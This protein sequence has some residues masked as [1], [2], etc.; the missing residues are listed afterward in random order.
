MLKKEQKK[1][2]LHLTYLQ[3]KKVKLTAVPTNIVKELL[4]LQFSQVCNLFIF[5]WFLIYTLHIY[6]KLLY[7]KVFNVLYFSDTDDENK[8]KSLEENHSYSLPESSNSK[9]NKPLKISSQ[10]LLGS[11]RLEYILIFMF[12]FLL[13]KH[14]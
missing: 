2:N 13:F 7:N 5:Y 8:D 1:P 14:R 4:A 6:L 9:K 3:L 10:V 12:R 11:S